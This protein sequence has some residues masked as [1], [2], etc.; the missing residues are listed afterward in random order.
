MAK[1]RFGRGGS[2]KSNPFL[3]NIGKGRRPVAKNN[4]KT[5]GGEY[6]LDGNNYVGDFHIM[7]DGRAMTGKKHKGSGLFGLRSKRK[8]SRY[9]EPVVTDTPSDTTTDVTPTPTPQPTQPPPP[10]P[11][12]KIPEPLPPVD[13][14]GVINQP[15]KPLASYGN[16]YPATDSSVKA[17]ANTN[18]TSYYSGGTVRGHLGSS[19]KIAGDSVVLGASVHPQ[20]S[21]DFIVR[22]DGAAYTSAQMK[23]KIDTA[24]SEGNWYYINSVPVIDVSTSEIKPY[25]NSGLFKQEEDYAFNTPTNQIDALDELMATID[26]TCRKQ[27]NLEEARPYTDRY[28]SKD[29]VAGRLDIDEVIASANKPPKI[30]WRRS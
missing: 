21:I 17:A 6:T 11:R 5:T 20:L 15:Y 19:R 12:P 22:I 24:R 16:Q 25:G 27:A 29:A 9:L 1:R 13:L 3:K 2:S 14:T 28:D 26:W 18:V 30:R 4:L 8:R 7:S 10:P 23:G